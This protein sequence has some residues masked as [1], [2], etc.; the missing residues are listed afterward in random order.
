MADEGRLA[1]ILLTRTAAW[2]V[3]LAAL[4]IGLVVGRL[5]PRRRQLATTEEE[6]AEIESKLIDYRSMNAALDREDDELWRFR[7]SLPPRPLLERLSQNSLRVVTFANLKGGVGKTTSTANIA[8]A[9]DA[10]GY[11][12]LV[13][14]LDYQGSLSA[15]MLRASNQPRLDAS[16]ADELIAGRADGAWIVENARPLTGVL[17][18]TRL[19]TAGYTLAR[20]ENRQMLRWLARNI[21]EDIRYNL[22]RALMAN[23]VQAAF[24]VVLIDAAPRLTTGTINALLASSHFVVPTILDDLSTETLPS[25]LRQARTLF[26]EALNPNLELAGVL[27]TMTDQADLRDHEFLTL[28]SVREAVT[29]EWGPT[30][31]VFQ[32][33]IPDRATVA[34][35]AGKKLAYVEDVG[36]NGA[37]SF[38]GSAAD[39]LVR[40]IGL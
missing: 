17:D 31:F 24:D 11:R 8:A 5:M 30:G 23:E 2:V 3:L 32:T 26:R 28:Q 20:V 33:N 4:L 35:S 39:E 37:R 9:L 40:R 27:A 38:F 29:N 34:K 7:P 18:R 16:M 22:L 13:I 10:A 36:P 19:I 1:S 21:E 12:V 14:D 25:F 6:V 15:M